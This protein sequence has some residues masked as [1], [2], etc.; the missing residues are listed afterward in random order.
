LY[1]TIAYV[2]IFALLWSRRT[3]PHQPGAQFAA[4][5]VLSSIARFL[6]EF[7][8][9]NPPLLFGLSQAQVISLGLI[10]VGVFLFIAKREEPSPVAPPVPRLAREKQQ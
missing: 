7:V 8:R 4:Y 9:V 2:A 10:A 5:L 6:L 3:Q 1:E